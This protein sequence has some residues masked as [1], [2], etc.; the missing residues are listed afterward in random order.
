M[1]ICVSS[2]GQTLD[3]PVDPRFG[4]AQCFVIVDTDTMEFEAMANPAMSAGGGA[5]TKASQLVINKGAQAVVTGNVGP[6]AFA[7]LQSAGVAIHIGASGT[8]RDAV[9]A[10]QA[11]KLQMVAAPS[12][13]AHA[14]AG[15]APGRG[16]P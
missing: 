8:V 1:K 12:V 3:A 6:N 4:R 2:T 10:L 16:R 15:G 11:G 5:G 9:A 7:V 14:G 13:A